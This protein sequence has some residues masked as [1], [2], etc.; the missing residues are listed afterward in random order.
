[1]MYSSF[2]SSDCKTKTPEGKVKVSSKKEVREVLEESS[3]LVAVPSDSSSKKGKKKDEKGKKKSTGHTE[4][5][6]SP[7]VVKG[8]ERPLS[9]SVCIPDGRPDAPRLSATEHVVTLTS[10]EKHKMHKRKL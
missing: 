10:P 2:L 3:M 6:T 8:L 7:I 9:V 5:T 4:L 1:M